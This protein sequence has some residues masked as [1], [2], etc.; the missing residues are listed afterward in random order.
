MHAGRKGHSNIINHHCPL[1][2]FQTI[3]F[4]C[5]EP[6]KRDEHVL[7]VHGEEKEG[8]HQ[9][10][11]C[12]PR[13]GLCWWWRVGDSVEVLRPGKGEWGIVRYHPLLHNFILNL[14]C[15]WHFGVTNKNANNNNN[16]SNGIFRVL[17]TTFETT[18]FSY[19]LL[20][21][22]GTGGG[23]RGKLQN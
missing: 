10:C 9:E 1:K 13:C 18:K 7:L 17:T 21:C 2:E 11:D 12:S 15:L 20:Q 3:F 14:P 23:I 19:V 8:W 5:A 4:W 6:C 16:S 22:T